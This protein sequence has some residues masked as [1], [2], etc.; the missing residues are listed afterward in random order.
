MFI[1]YLTSDVSISRPHTEVIGLLTTLSCRYGASSLT[2]IVL[3]RPYFT[4]IV[5]IFVTIIT[6]LT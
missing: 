3:L 1:L 6:L 2:L 5:V 4:I